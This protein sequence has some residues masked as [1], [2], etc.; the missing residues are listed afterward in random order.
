MG[1]TQYLPMIF[2]LLGVVFILAAAI[3]LRGII[4][5]G[6]IEELE[7]ADAIVVFGAAVWE[8]GPSTTL[9]FRVDRAV[10]VFNEG[11]APV[12]LCSGGWSRGVSEAAVMR[13][14]MLEVGLPPEAVIPDDGGSTTRDSIRSTRLFQGRDWKRVLLVSS[15]YH[16]HRIAREARRQG[17]TPVLCPT[18]FPEHPDR[19]AKAFLIRQYLREVL[20]VMSYWLSGMLESVF[21]LPGICKIR[22][23]WRQL[24]GRTRSL[25]G[26]ADAVA[27]AGEAIT[28]QIKAAKPDFSDTRKISTPASGLAWPVSGEVGDGFGLRHRR[29]HAGV[30]LRVPYG[31]RVLASA[32]GKVIFAEPLGPYGNVVVIDHQGGLSTVYAHLSGMLVTEGDDADSADCIGYVGVTGRSSGPHLHFE[33]RV[34]GSPVDPLVYLETG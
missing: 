10:D 6:R 9:R 18:P 26:G 14:L 7:K 16:M 28:W 25:F 31:S 1:D 30:D 27:A 4:L 23:A 24:Y 2:A 11:W 13:D 33:V 15:P 34:H 22:S 5:D 29:L 20:A 21:D 12:V 19:A 3:T 17:L 8:E 32:A